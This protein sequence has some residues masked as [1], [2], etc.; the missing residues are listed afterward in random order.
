MAES[1]DGSCCVWKSTVGGCV[2][3]KKDIE[4]VHGNV[5]EDQ[6]EFRMELHI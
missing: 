3:A 1:L 6:C 4:T 5:K 2:T